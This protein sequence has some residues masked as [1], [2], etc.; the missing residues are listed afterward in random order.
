MGARTSP[1]AWRART[2]VPLG[3]S[4]LHRSARCV[5]IALV[6]LACALATVLAAAPPAG[7]DSRAAALAGVAIH[8]WRVGP[9]TTPLPFWPLRNPGTR[10]QVFSAIQAMGVKQA[11]VDLR[12]ERVEPI[13]K[14]LRDWSEFD[15]IHQSAVAHGITLLPMVAMPPHWANSGRGSWSFPNNPKDFEDFLTAAIERYPDIPAWEIWNEPNLP[16]FSQ[17]AVDAGAFVNLLAAAHRAK[18]RA[19]SSA[20]IVS[21]GLL[22]FGNATRQ[23]FDQMVQ[24]HAFDYVDGFGIHPYSEGDPD[25]AGS[26]FLAL[27][28]FHD[29]L[30]QIGKPDVGIWVTEYGAPTSTVASEYSVPLSGTGQADRLRN[31]FAIA[32]R[33]SWIKNLTWYEFQDLCVNPADFT[34]NFGLVHEDM[35]PKPAAGALSGVVRGELPKIDSHIALAGVPSSAR[36]RLRRG[37]QRALGLGGTLDTVAAEDA[38]RPVTLT[39]SWSP[40]RG[41][42]AAKTRTIGLSARGGRFSTT[43]RHLRSGYW[44]AV[45]SYAGSSD[46]Y[47]STST[48]LAFGVKRARGR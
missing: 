24:L 17:P 37:T 27:P 19:G 10:E 29:R 6:A 32:A 16:G 47:A 23:F 9:D 7:A 35:S 42:R 30:V 12:W 44:R 28:Y 3:E 38:V 36:L 20:A 22:W 39:L 31:A 11:R 1:P 5:R 40:K 33:W 2:A 43:L 41:G 46:Y 13:A 8:P 4:A 48:P 26:G 25:A 45:A 34:C 18:E 14:G 21:G 15:G